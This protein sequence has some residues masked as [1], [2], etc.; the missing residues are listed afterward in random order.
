MVIYTF[1]AYVKFTHSISYK[2]ITW[3]ALVVVMPCAWAIGTPGTFTSVYLNTRVQDKTRLGRSKTSRAIRICMTRRCFVSFFTYTL[4]SNKLKY[5]FHIK[6]NLT[7]LY[8]YI[9]IYIDLICI[10]P[11]C[12]ITFLVTE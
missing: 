11:V 8:I 1:K 5:L 6:Q 9:Y 2:P 3:F 12:V 7:F 10:L 4:N